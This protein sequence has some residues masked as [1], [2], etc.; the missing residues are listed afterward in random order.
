[1]KKKEWKELALKLASE[2]NSLKMQIREQQKNFEEVRTFMVTEIT[3]AMSDTA[4]KA[5]SE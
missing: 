1:M 2:N 3:K 4:K 5:K